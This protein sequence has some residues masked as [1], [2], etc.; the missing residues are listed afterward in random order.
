MT[1]DAFV[2]PE[3]KPWSAEARHELQQVAV[4][5]FFPE[6]EL[7]HDRTNWWA[8][9]SGCLAAWL[10]SH[11][12]EPQLITE[13]DSE[14]GGRAAFRCRRLPGPLPAHVTAS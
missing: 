14:P 12:F 13:W 3:S 10:R 5:Q 1:K 11:G 4:A 9:T 2:G 6:D 8:P 7:G